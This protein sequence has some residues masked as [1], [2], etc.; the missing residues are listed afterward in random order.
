MKQRSLHDFF[1]T[2]PSK[3]SSGNTFKPPQQP[4]EDIQEKIGCK[5]TKKRHVVHTKITAKKVNVLDNFF[6]ITTDTS[7]NALLRRERIRI[8]IE[9]EAAA[10]KAAIKEERKKEREKIKEMKKKAMKE[11]L[12]LIEELERQKK[13]EELIRKSGGGVEIVKGIYIGTALTAANLQFLIDNN[14]MS[15]VNCT[16][17]VLCFFGNENENVNEMDM[18]EDENLMDKENGVIEENTKKDD[19]LNENGITNIL[20]NSMDIVNDNT[21]SNHVVTASSDGNSSRNSNEIN[22][23]YSND[24]NDFQQRNYL[25]IPINDTTF[26]NIEQYFDTVYEFIESARNKNYNVLIHC[27]FGK[28]RSASF[29]ISYLMKKH[30]LRVDDALQLIERRGWTINLNAGF[31]GQLLELE[32]VLFGEKKRK[33]RIK[34]QTPLSQTVTDLIE[35]VSQPKPST[36]QSLSQKQPDLYEKES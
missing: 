11:E 31:Y 7:E 15:I 24:S 19:M 10:I 20:N 14:I 36:Q 4:S 27:R 1:K 35:E 16:P 32:A 25:R 26:E 2:K 18:E 29:V 30:A 34:S 17:N 6:K 21:N 22:S 23:D 28:S 12:K 33:R 9:K 5:P 3:N 13:E 8:A